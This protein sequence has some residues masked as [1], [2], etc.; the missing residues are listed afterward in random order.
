M[1]IT[2][3][4]DQTFV[5]VEELNTKVLL[6]SGATQPE[7]SSLEVIRPGK[8]LCEVT[9]EELGTGLSLSLSNGHG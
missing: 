1:L 6:L 8:V 2:V 9:E 4:R 5:L 7:S 3:K